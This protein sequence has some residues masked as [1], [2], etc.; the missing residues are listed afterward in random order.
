[1]R[2]FGFG[3]LCSLLGIALFGAGLSLATSE[4]LEEGFFKANQAYKEGRFQEACKE[5]EQLIKGGYK[6]GHLFYNLGN[7]R[8]RLEELGRAIL[9]YERAR[10]FV[11]RD[12]DLTFNLGYAREQTK[13][14]VPESRSLVSLVF[15]WLESFSL[16]ELFWGFA[17]LNVLFWGTVLVRLFLRADWLYY[18]FMGL[19]AFWLIAGISFGLKWYQL[20]T[21]DRAVILSEEVDVLAGPHSQD[22]VLFKLHAGTVVFQE[23]TEDGWSL[24]SLPEKKRGWLK[25]EVIETI[26]NSGHL[27]SL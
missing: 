6:N 8:F 25:S 27:G 26:M 14:A 5:Y 19:L 21:D 9:N 22:T 16:N 7:A 4:P 20:E 23:R 10:L 13:D 24:I 11:P 18:T 2:T 17:A 12:A 15:F 1:M 3:V